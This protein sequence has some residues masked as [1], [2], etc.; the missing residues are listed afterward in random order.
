MR[1]FA[2]CF[3]LSVLLPLSSVLYFASCKVGY[4]FTGASVPPEAETFSVER[5]P[6][7]AG[8]GPPTLSQTFTQDLR[9]RFMRQTDLDLTDRNGDIQYSGSIVDYEVEPVAVQGNQE[10][11]DQASL[12]RLTMTVKVRYRN[13]IEEKDSFER[14]FSR[15]ADFEADQ[16][17]SDVENELI[18]EINDQLTQDIF[19]ASLS[20][21]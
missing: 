17:L 8:L 9:D 6:N 16:S 2:K 10:G 4:S 14:E 13:T 20:D 7:N 19:D 15:F 5:F 3:L 11:N 12:N 21:W 1:K 18:E